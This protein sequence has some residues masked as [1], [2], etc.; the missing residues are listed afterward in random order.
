MINI[1]L[2]FVSIF[3]VVDIIEDIDKL[4]NQEESLKKTF[5]HFRALQEKWRNTG[6][7]PIASRTWYH[8]VDL[9]EYGILCQLH[10]E[11]GITKLT[12]MN[13]VLLRYPLT[14]K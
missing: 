4:T 11:H 6:H 13:T 12:W 2:I 10:V 5:E 1:L 3:L 7:V 9:D 14:Q 8:R